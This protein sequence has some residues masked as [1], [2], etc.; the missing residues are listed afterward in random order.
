MSPNATLLRYMTTYI[1]RNKSF[2]IIGYSN[3]TAEMLLS[4]RCED[5]FVERYIRT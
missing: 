2:P 5:V 3:V 4:Q 1:V